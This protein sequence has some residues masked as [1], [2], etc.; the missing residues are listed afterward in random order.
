MLLVYTFMCMIIFLRILILVSKVTKPLF[1]A[2]VLEWR[3]SGTDCPALYTTI[4]LYP[5]LLINDDPKVYAGEV[6]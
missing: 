4:F 1:L 6:G 2:R 3:G 5:V